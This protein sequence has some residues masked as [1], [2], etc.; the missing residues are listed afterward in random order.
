MQLTSDGIYKQIYNLDVIMIIY[1]SIL[2]LK[3]TTTITVFA[4]ATTYYY[5]YY[6]DYN[7]CKL[8]GR[9]VYEK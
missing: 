5:C 7:T 2:C 3:R 9:H 1:L 4:T 6:Y 8:I